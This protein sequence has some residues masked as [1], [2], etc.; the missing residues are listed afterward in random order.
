MSCVFKII[1]AL[2]ILL[3][4]LV[5]KYL[6]PECYINLSEGLTRDRGSWRRHIH[7]VDYWCP[8]RL[9]FGVIAI[10][11]SLVSVLVFVFFYFV[12]V[13]TYLFYQYAFILSFPCN[14]VSLFLSNRGTL[15]AA[16]FFIG[17]SCRC[18]S[19]P[20]PCP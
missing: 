11:F 7:V 5:L 8:L 2:I 9:S 1:L 6:F 12:V 13:T 18:T 10:L 15:L 20:I 19:L 16:L 4:L 17:M 14:Y 3:N